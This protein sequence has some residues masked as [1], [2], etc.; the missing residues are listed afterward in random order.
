M[1]QVREGLVWYSS[2]CAYWTADFNK[3]K[4]TRGIPCCPD[5][6]C[7]GFEVEIDEWEQGAIAFDKND[8]GYYEFLQETKET[9]SQIS[10]SAAWK[11]RKEK[12]KDE[13]QKSVQR[14]SRNASGGKT[15]D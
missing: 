13:N 14:I 9:C 1:A 15:I 12:K 10:T 8:E 7:V 2:G 4:T 11:A 3:L 5:C 6:G